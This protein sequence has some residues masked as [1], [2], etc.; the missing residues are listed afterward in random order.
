MPFAMLWPKETPVISRRLDGWLKRAMQAMVLVVSTSICAQA[1]PDKAIQF[2]VPY[3]AGSISDLIARLVAADLS[4]RLKQ[5]VVVDNRTGAGGIIGLKALQI[6]RPDG[7]TIGLIVSGSVVQPWLRRDM[8]FDV[9]KDFQPITLMFAGPLML[10]VPPEFPARSFPEFLDYAKA[11]PHKIFFGSSGAGTATHLSAELLKQA[12]AV[13]MTHVPFRGS[14]E[15]YT[16]MFSG[17]VNAYFDLFGTAKPFLES[18]RVRVLG[19]T[20]RRRLGAL[21]NVPAIAE[22][23]PGFEVLGWT[24]LAAPKGT[25]RNIVDKL[26]TELRAVFQAPEMQKR[27]MDM[28]VEPGGNSPAEMTEFIASEYDKWGRITKDAGMKAE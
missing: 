23:L 22:Y 28:G 21:P 4:E 16:A 25:P 1:Y 27:L 7:Y 11:N 12:A 2:I 14:S 5:Q 8:P 10:V 19:V 13:E 26:A 3:S 9:R 17:N 15:V 24:G 6:A 20:S 18:G